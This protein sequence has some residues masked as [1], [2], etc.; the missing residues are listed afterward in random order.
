[1]DTL[2]ET[3]P[4]GGKSRWAGMANY[5][6]ATP[7]L[8]HEVDLRYV[9]EPPRGDSYLELRVDD[10]K[11]PGFVWGCM[12]AVDACSRYLASSWMA[13]RYERKTVVIDL[14]QHRFTVLPVHIADFEFHWP[15]LD[16]RGI[17]A[18]RQYEFDGSEVWKPF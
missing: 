14:E 11:L 15:L 16:G 8:N 17:A 5:I 4:D 1:M 6:L 3:L 13:E 12:F 10:R 2:R 18:G 7:D 9:D